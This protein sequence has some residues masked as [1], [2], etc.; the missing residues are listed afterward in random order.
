MSFVSQTS[1]WCLVSSIF[2]KKRICCF[3]DPNRKSVFESAMK[4]LIGG[5]SPSQDSLEAQPGE[6]QGGGAAS[7]EKPAVETVGRFL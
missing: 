3:S 5:D 2:K 7:A 1:L 4:L 6:T